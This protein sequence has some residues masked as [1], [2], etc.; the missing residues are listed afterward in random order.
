MCNGQQESHDVAAM[1]DV[2]GDDWIFAE[3]WLKENIAE[4][5]WY[6]FEVFSKVRVIFKYSLDADA[7]KLVWG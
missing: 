6:H 4:D 5:T 3:Q 7:F 1:V 2:H